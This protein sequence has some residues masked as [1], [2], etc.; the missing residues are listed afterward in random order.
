MSD[1]ISFAWRPQIGPQYDAIQATWCNEL[2][3]GGARFGGKSDYLL[4]DFLQDVPTYGKNWQ[5]I[6]FRRSYKQLEDLINRSKELYPKTGAKWLEGKSQWMWKC[7]AKLR[8]RFLDRDADAENY[9]G[10]SYTWMGWDELGN[11]PSRDPYDKLKACCRW[12]GAPVPTKRIRATGN[13]GGPGQGWIKEYFIDYAP[14]GRRERIDPLTKHR[15]MFIP[16]RVQDNKIGLEKDPGYVDRLRGTGSAQLVRAWL[17]GDWNAVIGG[18]FPEFGPAHIIQPYEIPAH[19]TRFRAID[20]GSAKPFVV[21]WCAL[22]DGSDRRFPPNALIVYREWYG[23]SAANVGLKLSSKEVAEGIKD[24]EPR[25]EKISYTVIDP[26]AF[27]SDDGPSTGERLINFGIACQPADNKRI[28]GWQQVRDRLIGYD[29]KPLLYIFSTCQHLI[30][31]LPALQHDEKKPEDLD[32]EGDD[33]AADALRYGCMS[34]PYTPPL[35]GPREPIRGI[36]ESTYE[37]IINLDDFG[38]SGPW[39]VRI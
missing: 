8:F 2:F 14:L 28:V 38:S 13:P 18:Y 19:F 7:G 30:R 24:R 22:S 15:I 10:H 20:W 29:G 27:N 1:D 11:F 5:G 39:G 12:G 26:A 37:E 17:E 34:R 35:P 21:L 25:S 4:G 16:S 36:R 9:Q 32:T 23:G 3:F 31:T 6:V 33:H